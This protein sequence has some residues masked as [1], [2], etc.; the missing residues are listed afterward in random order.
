MRR[1]SEGDR[2]WLAMDRMIFLSTIVLLTILF[3]VYF[4]VIPQLPWSENAKSFWMAIVTNII[5]VFLLSSIFYALFRNDQE[6]REEYERRNLASVILEQLLPHLDCLQQNIEDIQ[7]EILQIKERQVESSRAIED[8][9]Y[10][11]NRSEQPRM[12]A[13]L[14]KVRES[15]SRTPGLPST[16][17]GS[18]TRLTIEYLEGDD[19]E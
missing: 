16:R 8:F 1:N 11:T 18:S 15:N 5:P 7:S 6:L 14:Q 19:N 9:L 12:P 2:Y 3:L 17:R 10:H 13:S 4:Y